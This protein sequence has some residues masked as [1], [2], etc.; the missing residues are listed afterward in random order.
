VNVLI[1]DA[2]AANEG[3][4]KFSRDAIG[5]GPRLLAGICNKNNTIS[6]IAR[7]EDLL[8]KK[9]DQLILSSDVFLISAMTVDEIAVRRIIKRIRK[10]TDSTLITL[11]GP[12]TNDSEIPQELDIDIAVFGEGEYIVDELIKGDFSVDSLSK[13]NNDIQSINGTHYIKRVNSISLSSFKLFE[14]SIQHIRNYPDYWF[15]KV[16]VETVRGCSNFYRGELVKQSGSC[17][18]CGNCDDIDEILVGD[19]PEDILPG[20]GF[21]SVP[22]VFGPSRSRSIDLIVKE[23]EGLFNEGARRIILSAPGFLDFQRERKQEQL[24]SPSTPQVNLESIEELLSK[25]SKIRDSQSNLCSISIEN[26]KPTL[27]DNEVAKK[28]GKYL[29]DTSISIG[30]ETFDATHS[31]QIGRPSSP[32]QAIK[33]ARYFKEAGINPQIYLIHSLPGENVRA[34][35]KTIETIEGGLADIAE[36][37]TVYRYLPLPDSPFT[38]TKVPLPI[39]RHLLNTKREKLKETII[40]FNY[41]KKQELLDAEIT[42]I[43]AEEDKARKNTYICY[44]LRSG[45]AISVESKENII[46]KTLKIKIE[47]VISD[48]LVS[49]QIV[50]FFEPS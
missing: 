41:R 4:R 21:C 31:E 17:S 27:V 40:E 44:P 35:N 9:K 46:G 25:L 10:M 13:T 3:R 38:K 20:C 45:P 23:V 2:L 50:D 48:K 43:A 37:I 32:E 8:E 42:V 7:V 28:I 33:A 26:V 14:P 12:I 1:V 30:C 11:G 6:T 29:P 34:L 47:G 24:Y 18:D 16:Y 39:E 49:G 5:V 36:K 22:S 15:S 19:C